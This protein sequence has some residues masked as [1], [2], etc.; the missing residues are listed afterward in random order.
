M[1]KL[2]NHMSD[3]DREREKDYMKNYYYE[4]KKNANSFN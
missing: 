3:E 1:G 4:R 2:I